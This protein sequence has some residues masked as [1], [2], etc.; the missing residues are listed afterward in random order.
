[1]SDGP[2]VEWQ[3]RIRDLIRKIRR[4]DLRVIGGTPGLV[5]KSVSA[6]ELLAARHHVIGQ[7]PFSLL[8]AF[9]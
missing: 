2:R 1:M 9:C 5:T 7:R 4:I 8:N 3:I 6:L